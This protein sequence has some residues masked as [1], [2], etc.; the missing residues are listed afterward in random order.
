VTTWQAR[1]ERRPT[2]LFAIDRK[3]AK[4]LEERFTEA[5]IAC[6]Y[7]DGNTP[8]FD[9]VDMFERFRAGETKIISSV[10][11]MDTGVDL[12]ICSC[13]IDARPT[14]SVIRDVQGKGRGLRTAPGKEN[15]IILDH[16]GNTRHLGLINSIDTDILDD[17]EAAVSAEQK[18]KDRAAPAIVLCPECHV[19]L[20]K[21]KPAKCP[22]C[23]H[24]FF[25][26]IVS[27]YAIGFA[28]GLAWLAS[29]YG[30]GSSD[31]FGERRLHLFGG[32]AAF[33]EWGCWVRRY[34]RG[35]AR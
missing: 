9:R 17:G 11:T 24:V 16:A 12:P 33:G 7:V 8:M 18:K 10:G 27:V 13:I 28:L 5:G 31:C 30:C 29:W 3:H 4:H 1:G 20:P 19:V 26:V 34:Y 21:P 15:L 32:A 14:K 6:E 2:I 23:G 22:Q 35:L 25:A